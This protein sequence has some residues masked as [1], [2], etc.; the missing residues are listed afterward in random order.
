MLSVEHPQALCRMIARFAALGLNLTKAGS[1]P[2]WRR[3]F[4]SCSTLI[5]KASVWSQDVVQPAGMLLQ[6]TNSSCF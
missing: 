3:D 4:E 5:S 2:L 6:G 1:R